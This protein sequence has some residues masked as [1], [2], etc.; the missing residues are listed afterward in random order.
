MEVL[1]GRAASYRRS[2]STFRDLLIREFLQ[3]AETSDAGIVHERVDVTRALVHLRERGRRAEPAPGQ[4]E[5]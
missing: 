3:G 4:S 1:A 5:G 2:A